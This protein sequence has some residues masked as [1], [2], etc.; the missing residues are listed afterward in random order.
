M[1]DFSFDPDTGV[2]GWLHPDRIVYQMFGVG[3]IN[4][5]GNCSSYFTVKYLDMI[6]YQ[7]VCLLVP[8]TATIIAYLLGT[9]PAPALTVYI[10]GA[11]MLSGVFVVV[12]YG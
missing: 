12:R 3:L 2:F 11:I 5:I 8:A 9:D 1:F 6:V 10:G 4:A 7:T